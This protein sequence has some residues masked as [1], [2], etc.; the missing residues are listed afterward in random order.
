VIFCCGSNTLR[1]RWLVFIIYILSCIVHKFFFLAGIIHQHLDLALFSPD[2]HALVSH[3][4]HHIKRI[5]RTPT[6]GQ[7]QDIFLN[8]FL[9]CLFQ[10]VGNL[11]KPIGGTQ[12]ADALVGPLMIVIRNPKIGSRYRLVEAVELGPQ[13]E[14][15]LN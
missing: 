3:A 9:Q 14:F 8:A 6:K 2:D 11:E 10:I 1:V 7:F 15:V 4:A 5:N 12:A 13:E